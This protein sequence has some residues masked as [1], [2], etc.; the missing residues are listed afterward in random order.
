MEYL[1]HCS[2]CVSEAG[3]FNPEH[4]IVLALDAGAG[5]TPPK[6]ARRLRQDLSHLP[7]LWGASEEPS[8]WGWDAAVVAELL[9]RGVPRDRMPSNEQLREI[10]R[11]SNRSL[12]VEMLS[13]LRTLP[14]TIGTSTVCHTRDDVE[15]FAREHGSTI[16]KAPW[17]SSGRGVKRFTEHSAQFIDSTIAKQGSIIA[18]AECQRVMDFALEYEATPE[19]RVEYR[20]LSLFTTVNG[21]YKGNLLLPDEEKLAILAEHVDIELLRQVSLLIKQFLVPRLKGIYSGPLGV[22]MMVCQPLEPLEPFDPLEPL[23]PARTS[24]RLNQREARLELLNPC[25]EINL[26]RTMGHVALA[27]TTQGNRGTMSVLYNKERDKYELTVHS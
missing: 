9:K 1:S 24:E 6:A 21:A 20:G 5:F 26:R 12:A 13:R 18:E 3:V 4:D 17:S 8:V 14:G 19:G 10:R 11:L 27:L 23:E 22:D 7:S 25:I 2:P 15:Q 16:I